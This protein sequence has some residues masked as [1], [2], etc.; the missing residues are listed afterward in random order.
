[1]ANGIN[2]VILVGNLGNDPD[3]RYTQGGT[4]VCNISVATTESWKSKDGQREERTEWHR[5]V[6]FGKLGEIMD[7]Y[8]RKGSKVYIEG[9]LR[10][11]K[12]TDKEGVER[13]TTKV[14]ADEMRMLDGR[15]DDEGRGQPQREE[16]QSYGGG[17]GGGRSQSSAPPRSAPSGGTRRAPPQQ[18]SSGNDFDDDDIPF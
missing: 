4:T 14:Y 15:R 1:M 11:E 2:K 13:Y 12:Y 7:E 16:R 17:G 5:V 8:L 9:K 3:T 10:T 6:A 18:Q